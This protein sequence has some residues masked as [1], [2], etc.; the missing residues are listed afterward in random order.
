[1]ECWPWHV[2]PTPPACPAP[3]CWWSCCHSVRAESAGKRQPSCSPPCSSSGFSWSCFHAVSLPEIPVAGHLL[4]TPPP[5][6]HKPK[7]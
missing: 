5:C 4:K 7:S 1:V 3:S 2:N 6:P